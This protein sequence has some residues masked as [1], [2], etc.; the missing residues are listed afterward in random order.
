MS[1]AAAAGRQSTSFHGADGADA[2]PSS[3]GSASHDLA[4]FRAESCSHPGARMAVL[5]RGQLA[6]FPS[7]GR[8][9]EPWVLNITA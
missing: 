4:C 5:G 9:T 7:G 8:R 1:L 2:P 3:R 6:D